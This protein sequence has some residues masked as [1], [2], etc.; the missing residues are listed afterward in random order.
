M[1]IVEQTERSRVYDNGMLEDGETKVEV[2]GGKALL[3]NV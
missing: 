1:V 3:I 2:V